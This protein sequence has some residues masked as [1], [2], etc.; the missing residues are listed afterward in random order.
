MDSVPREMEW[1]PLKTNTCAA[2]ERC[3]GWLWVS[4]Q[5]LRKAAIALT[6]L[7]SYWAG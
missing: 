5:S 2:A 1:A 3:P 6:D 4:G 7:G